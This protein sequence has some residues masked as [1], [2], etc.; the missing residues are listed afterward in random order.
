MCVVQQDKKNT[1]TRGKMVRKKERVECKKGEW[2]NA[3]LDEIQKAGRGHV[4]RH[5]QGGYPMVAGVRVGSRVGKMGLGSTSVTRRPAALWPSVS[6]GKTAAQHPTKAPYRGEPLPGKAVGARGEPMG[7]QPG[8]G[9]SR[10]AQ[11]P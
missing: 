2:M 11:E 10:P 1:E 8:A 9:A 7:S 5:V 6:V 3:P 4:G